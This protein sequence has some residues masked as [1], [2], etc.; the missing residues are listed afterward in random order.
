MTRTGVQEYLAA[1]GPRYRRERKAEKRRLL[2]EAVAVTGYHRKAVVRLLGTAERRKGREGRGRPRR[3]GVEL[4]EPLR[5]A[6]EATGRVCS[7]RLQPFLPELLAQLERHGQLWLT[8]GDRAQLEAMSASTIDRLLRPVRQRAGR[9]PLGTTKP[10][11]LLKQAI[12]I[13]TFTEWDDRRPGFLEVDLVAHCGESTEGFYLHTLNAV[14]IATGWVERQAVWGKR[15]QR[16]GGALHELGQRLPFPWLGLDSD[17]GSEFINKDLLAYC[18]QHRI[19]FTRSRPS[20]KNDNAHVE[21]KNWT[22][23]RQVV[24]YDRFSSRQAYETLNRLY[25]LLRWHANFFQPVLLLQ[26]KTRHGARVRKRYDEAKTPYQRVLETGVLSEE[27]RA[28]LAATYA[29]L[30]P[31]WLMQEITATQEQLWK[32]AEPPRPGDAERGGSTTKTR[33][34]RQQQRNRRRPPTNDSAGA[35]A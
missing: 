6:W 20:K 25:G 7:R 21:G 27:Q 1:I 15:Q 32:L 5:Q 22:A 2:D 14:D 34:P 35:V 9:R 29:R 17:N 4:V 18:R 8:P 3:Y 26:E 19:T 31:V 11:T 24:G 12:P 10:G 30:N 16:V 13:R 23:V 28:R 33:P